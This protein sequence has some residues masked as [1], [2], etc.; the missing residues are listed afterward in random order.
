MLAFSENNPSC[1]P[2]RVFAPCSRDDNR[3]PCLLFWYKHHPVPEC[4]EGITFAKHKL[5]LFEHA[6]ALTGMDRPPPCI[7]C[8]I[9]MYEDN[10]IAKL[11]S[12]LWIY[13]ILIFLTESD[14][15]S[16][17]ATCKLA[18]AICL[19]DIVWKML[20]LRTFL[21]PKMLSVDFQG[22]QFWRQD[23]GRLFKEVLTESYWRLAFIVLYQLERTQSVVHSTVLHSSL[24]YSECLGS[25]LEGSF[26]SSK[27]TVHLKGIQKVS[28]VEFLVYNHTIRAWHRRNFRS[29]K[30]LDIEKVFKE[31]GIYM[32]KSSR[33]LGVVRQQGHFLY[34]DIGQ[35]IFPVG[36]QEC[37]SFKAY[38]HN[39]SHLLL[40]KNSLYDGGRYSEEFWLFDIKL[41]Q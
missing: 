17:S 26:H 33:K 8:D 6:M 29:I 19:E 21:D 4:G 20:C 37:L 34:T 1:K 14:I 7:N 3:N 25:Q 5:S 32:L 2:Y 28:C 35:R 23:R 22:N 27:G 40:C 15:L 9:S 31:F 18:R 16:F 30:P 24:Q 13:H 10:M 36:G 38:E 11:S 39:G 41:I 12:D